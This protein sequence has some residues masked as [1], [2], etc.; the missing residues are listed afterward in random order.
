[1]LWW[2]TITH[3]SHNHC[4]IL[5]LYGEQHYDSALLSKEKVKVRTVSNA[6]II[7]IQNGEHIYEDD[8]I[9]QKITT[10]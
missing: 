1:M 6:Q 7:A 3:S 8:D 2:G 10:L 9:K 5:V 4:L